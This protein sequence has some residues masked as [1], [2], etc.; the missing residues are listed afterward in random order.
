MAR[1]ASDKIFSDKIFDSAKTP[2]YNGCQCGRAAKVYK[3]SLPVLIL[4]LV[5]LKI[6]LC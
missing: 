1:T 3:L 5:L 4:R 6:K 2:K